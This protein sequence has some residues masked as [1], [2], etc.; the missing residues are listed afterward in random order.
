M[1]A[2]ATVVL[3]LVVA[4]VER[5]AAVVVVE[6]V[7]VV[8]AVAVESD[9]TAVEPTVLAVGAEGIAA[10]IVVN[11]NQVKKKILEN[12]NKKI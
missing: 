7:I 6:I 5:A 10:A 9:A 12:S 1:A 4:V 3:A 11:L 8:V 2:V